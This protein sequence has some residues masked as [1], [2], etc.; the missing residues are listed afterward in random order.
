MLFVTYLNLINQFKNEINSNYN[1]EHM[2]VS[3]AYGAA[4]YEV[5][6]DED[7]E[8]MFSRADKAMYEIKEK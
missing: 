3:M 7:F 4:V 5:E 6:E 8:E 2:T 1:E